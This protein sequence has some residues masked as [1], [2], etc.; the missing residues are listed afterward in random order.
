V[1]GAHHGGKEIP[2]GA[3]EELCRE[4]QI[5]LHSPGQFTG[6]RQTVNLISKHYAVR[7]DLFGSIV[8]HLLMIK[9]SPISRARGQK[10]KATFGIVGSM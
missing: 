5:R 3:R 6:R 7:E 9:D 2:I 4:R 1:V 10:T 8:I